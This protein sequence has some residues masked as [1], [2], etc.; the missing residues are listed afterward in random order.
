[1]VALERERERDRKKKDREET[2][3]R[4]VRIRE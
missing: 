4:A 1:V 3:K 2:G